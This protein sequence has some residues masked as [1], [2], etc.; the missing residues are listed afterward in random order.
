MF[1]K[2][3]DTVPA[4]AVSEVWSN[5]SWPSGL[6]ARLRA[7][8]AAGAGAAVELDVLAGVEA[9]VAGVVAEELLLDVVLEELPQPARASRPTAIAARAGIECLGVRPALWELTVDPPMVVGVADQDAGHRRSF[10]RAQPVIGLRGCGRR[11]A[12][13]FVDLIP[14]S[15]QHVP[16]GA[17]HGSV[18]TTT[19][20]MPAIRWCSSSSSSLARR[21]ASVR[22]SP[23]SPPSVRNT[24]RPAL[25][26]SSLSFL[27]SDPVRSRISSSI[28]RL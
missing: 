1:V 18:W 17:A 20:A 8:A 23:G 4:F 27:G 6:A 13:R 28:S 26:D 2:L 22:G 7:P 16:P 15:G 19:S 14:A 9:V 3:I 10:P 5:F 25:V 24:T 21:C 12:S 11:S